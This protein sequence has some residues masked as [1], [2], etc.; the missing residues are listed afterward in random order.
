HLESFIHQR[1]RVNGDSLS[2]LPGG[3]IQCL[4]DGNAF[5]FRLGRVQ[6]RPT[7]GCEPHALDFVHAP[8]AHALMYRVVLAVDGKQRLALLFRFAGDQLPRSHQALFVGEPYLFSSTNSFEGSFESSHADDGA[9]HKINFRVR[10]HAHRACL[11]VNYLNVAETLA[12][13]LLAHCFSIFFGSQREDFWPP[14]P[15]LFQRRINIATGSHSDKL[16]ALRMRFNYAEG[17][18]ADGT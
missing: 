12:L 9:H 4:L 11:A 14:S 7:A 1:C 6:K 3:M 10:G 17:A 8:A 15:R 16:K 2:H 5:E 18:A 13:Q